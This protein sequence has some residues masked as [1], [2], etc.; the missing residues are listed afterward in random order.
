MANPILRAATHFFTQGAGNVAGSAMVRGLNR[1]PL[2]PA[3]QGTVQD[4]TMAVPGALSVAREQ[5]EYNARVAVAKQ[6]V[7]GTHPDV[8][9]YDAVAEST[10]PALTDGQKN[11]AASQA[12]A[13]R[14]NAGAFLNSVGIEP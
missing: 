5:T 2:A 14:A 7:G 1:Q 10:S 6:I 13:M 4:F 9:L 8:K 11:Y 3:M 12:E